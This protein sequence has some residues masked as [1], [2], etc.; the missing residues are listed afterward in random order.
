MNHFI[1]RS[2]LFSFILLAASMGLVAQDITVGGAGSPAINGGY[3]HTF[4]YAGKNAYESS[5][6]DIVWFYTEWRF[7]DPSGSGRWYYNT[8]NTALPPSGGWQVD[9]GTG[10]APTLT[11]NVYLSAPAGSGTSDD[12]YLIASL[13]DLYWM[14]Q[15]N[16]E[17]G[18]AFKQT[19]DIDASST[20]LW[21]SGAG[22]LPIGDVNG[23]SFSGSYDGQGYKITGIS[24]SRIATDRVGF[25]GGVS[26]TITNTILENPNI[27]GQSITG[28]LIGAASGATVVDC[29]VIGGTVR[30]DGIAGGLIGL[31]NYS[32]M[33]RCYSTTSVSAS[34]YCGGLIGETYGG[35]TACTDCYST[36][37]VS[38]TVSECGGLIGVA[39]GGTISNCYSSGSVSVAGGGVFIGILT[40]NIFSNCFWDTVASGMG[41]GFGIG[42]ADG[43]TGMN[44]TQMKKDSA[45]LLAGWS[46]AVWNIDPGIN[47]GYPFLKWQNPGG[48]PLPVELSSFTAT[49]SNSTTLLTW[50]TKTEMNNAGFEVERK[51]MINEQ[52]T[53]NSW[54][55]VGF[56]TGHGTT[57]SP[58]QYS[59]SD[60]VGT[61]GT[62]SYRLKQIDHNG[63][64]T[65]SQEIRVEV[66]GVPKEFALAQNYPN[67]FN[68]TTTI[69]F[70]LAEDGHVSLKVFDML[71]REVQTVVDGNLKAGELHN[72]VF[73]AS[74]LSSGIYFYRL[75]TTKNS[76][77]NKMMLLK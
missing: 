31:L 16:S 19:A 64:F 47:T 5:S 22:F 56:V 28:G 21:E 52:S 30:G 3:N 73:D 26:G 7:T 2:I 38:V 11:G 24:I 55:K 10:P 4:S 66:G 37:P 23:T 44:T 40:S 67:P 72:A 50:K 8:A 39:W 36:G 45:F 70:T 35:L 63:A 77:V 60:N 33:N 43:L 1:L 34:Q 46:G 51:S 69:S 17:W 27:A 68:P 14:T 9:G 54:T 65:Y 6:N 76:L 15:S 20:S 18:K 75:E 12:P 62:Y 48:T 71:G 57:N 49:T 42:S 25:F 59:Y 13:S 29:A 53:M 74:G 41:T 61:A 32:S 58:Q